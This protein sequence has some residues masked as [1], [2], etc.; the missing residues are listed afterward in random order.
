MAEPAANSRNGAGETDRKTTDRNMGFLFIFMSSIFLSLCLPVSPLQ[1]I[2][3][4]FANNF[5]YCRAEPA[6]Y[7][8]PAN[9]SRKGNRFERPLPPSSPPSAVLLRR[10]G[11]CALRGSA[12]LS[13]V[14]RLN[15]RA[16]AP[17]QRAASPERY[18]S[19]RPRRQEVNQL[20]QVVAFLSHYDH[21]TPRTGNRVSD[22]GG[23][24][25]RRARL[26]CGRRLPKAAWRF[27]SRRTPYPVAA[28]QAALPPAGPM[29]A[30]PG[31]N[32]GRG[33]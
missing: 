26:S 6:H 13:R 23:R 12:V 11:L 4:Q 19:P 21:A 30:G 20:R 16:L 7:Q 32:R 14:A 17:R 29:L 2:P 33:R 24:A 1:R 15:R 31:S 25:R 3:S 27:A 5:D 8:S 10:T 28:A 9:L 18:T 22:C